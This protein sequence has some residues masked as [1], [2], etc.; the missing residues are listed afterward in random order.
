MTC[1]YFID[2]IFTYVILKEFQK[3]KNQWIFVNFDLVNA[4]VWG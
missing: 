2:V 4:E 3:F 1:V